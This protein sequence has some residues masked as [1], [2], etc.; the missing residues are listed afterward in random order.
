MTTINSISGGKT[1]EKIKNHKLQLDLFDNHFND[2]DSG[3][4]GL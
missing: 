3:F 4:C 1:Y 2:C